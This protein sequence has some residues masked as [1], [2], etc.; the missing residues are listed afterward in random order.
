MTQLTMIAKFYGTQ[1]QQ[2]GRHFLYVVKKVSGPTF[3]ET[4]FPER[5]FGIKQFWHD[6]LSA[7]F[8]AVIFTV[9][10]VCQ[11]FLCRTHLTAKN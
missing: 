11:N 7:T 5:A 6:I 9:Q 8:P 1:F 3:P 10:I 4:N 2:K